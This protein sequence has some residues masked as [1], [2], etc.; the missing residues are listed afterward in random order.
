M[1]RI[2][3][4]L[5]L[6]VLVLM[7]LAWLQP[8]LLHGL[9]RRWDAWRHDLPLVG[10]TGSTESH[11]CRHGG[12]VSYSTEKCPVGSVEESI[13]AGTVNVVTMPAPAALPASAASLPTVRDLLVKP[14]EPSL[15][16]KRIERAINP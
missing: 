5:A 10:S 2:G 6:A 3:S 4:L 12:R 16:D 13:T 9:G 8:D 14:G 7:G 15:Q 1:R 11:K